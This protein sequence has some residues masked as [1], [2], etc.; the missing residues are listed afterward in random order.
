MS[1]TIPAG[2]I[3]KTAPWC[4]AE[5]ARRGRC[6]CC[7]TGS[8]VWLVT[9][10]G[11]TTTGSGVSS[12]SNPELG[13]DDRGRRLPVELAARLAG[14]DLGLEAVEDERG[15][16][17][18]AVDLRGDALEPLD[19]RRLEDIG[20]RLDL[21]AE[22]PQPDPLE[23]SEREGRVAALHDFLGGGRPVPFDVENGR[24]DGDPVL[25]GGEDDGLEAWRASVLHASPVRP[26]RSARRR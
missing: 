1:R 25:G 21:G 2:S 8:S 20:G 18:G 13:D 9:S 11:S 22:E 24:P 16:D 10:G 19:E 12:R 26:R 4:V 23:P 15:L 3:V 5:R 14:D 17:R 7:A 6:G